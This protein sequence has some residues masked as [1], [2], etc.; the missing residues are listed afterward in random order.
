M[1]D[2]K[3]RVLKPDV[4]IEGVNYHIGSL[5]DFPAGI[6]KSLLKDGVIKELEAPKL[7]KKAK[8]SATE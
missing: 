5:A 6:A 2:Y 4:E 3:Y 7:E 8:K 1:T